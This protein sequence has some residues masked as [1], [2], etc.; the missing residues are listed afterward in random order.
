MMLSGPAG[1]S[2]SMGA[3]PV[4]SGARGRGADHGSRVVLSVRRARRGG[5][6]RR[7]EPRPAGMNASGRVRPGAARGGPV[8]GTV[9]VAGRAVGQEAEPGSGR[10]VRTVRPVRRDGAAR[11]R[12][13]RR[14]EVRGTA[15][16]RGLPEPARG[17]PVMGTVRVAGRAVGQEA[18]PGSGRVVRSARQVR[19]GG[20]GTL[21]G[22][23]AVARSAS[24]RV[25]P[26]AAWIGGRRM[27]AVRV[28]RKVPG[29][30]RT[31]EA[32]REVSV[33]RDHGA[34]RGAAQTGARRRVVRRETAR[35]P[36]ML[37]GPRAE[38]PGPAA[39]TRNA[40]GTEPATT[41][42]RTS[43]RRA[44]PSA[45]LRDAMTG[46][47]AIATWTGVARGSGPAA[48]TAATTAR[49]VGAT[50]DETP[51]ASRSGVRGRAGHRSR[52]PAGRPVWL[53]PVGERGRPRTGAGRVAERGVRTVPGAT[54]SVPTAA[55]PASSGRTTEQ[56]TPVRGR[57][58]SHRTRSTSVACRGRCAPSYEVCPRRPP[59]S[60]GPT[61][62]WRWT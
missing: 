62:S 16:G 26:G 6:V 1:G 35:G 3:G 12:E 30:G 43:G 29:R 52:R 47:P 25:R 20:A 18:E 45:A 17:G 32:V 23:R 40:R 57:R 33:A 56:N 27:G 39:H 46:G 13:P 36:A 34:D 15:S 41:V 49:A 2:P 44:D 11:R 4:V 59:N 8:M 22:H 42:G 31:S 48:P 51:A 61:W 37:R 60:S 14:A 7:R 10:V 55:G 21:M 24:G 9:R 19:R 50:A 53:G 5:A 58:G 28:V 38:Q 54:V